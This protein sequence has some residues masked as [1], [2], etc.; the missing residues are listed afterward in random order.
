MTPRSWFL[1]QAPLDASR[2]WIVQSCTAQKNAAR[3]L[4]EANQYHSPFLELQAMTT[5]IFVY[6]YNDSYD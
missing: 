4:C 3:Q 5:K 2:I 1:V 6:Q